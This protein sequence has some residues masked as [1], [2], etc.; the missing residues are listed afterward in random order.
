MSVDGDDLVVVGDATLTDRR[1]RLFFRSVLG[2]TATEHGWRCPR[3][4]VSL[5]THIIRVN[6]FLERQGLQVER[7]GIANREVEHELARRRSF[8]RTQQAASQWKAGQPVVDLV[9]VKRQLADYGW[10]DQRALRPHQEQGLGHA[11]TAAN[12][13]NFS[14]PGAGKTVTA[15][16][17]AATHLA[18]GTVDV[19]LVVGPLACFGPWE[20]ETA[21]ALGDRLPTKRVRGAAPARRRTYI[22]TRRGNLLLI[23]FASAAADRLALMELCRTQNVML[24]IDESHRIKR[25]KGGYWAPALVAVARH[26]RVRMVLS[27]T[28]MPQ[29]GRD[30][31]TQLNILW[32]GGELTGSQ[33]AFATQVD[34]NFSALLRDIQPFMARTPKEALG[35]PPYKVERH[36]V[37]LTGTQLEI[38][39][40]IMTGLRRRLDDADTWVDKLE[41]LRRARPIRLLQAACNPDLF[42]RADNYYRLPRLDSDLRKLGEDRS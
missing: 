15:L 35:L 12:A 13:A 34:S 1:T 14:V 4:H 18:A 19:V 29:N 41:A 25:F 37:P 22:G 8:E 30:L 39:D 28:P 11:L 9:E 21:A 31:Y 17:V 26:A 20:K 38:Y 16:A 40:L 3:R 32:P 24:V 23:S 10:S 7:I 2:A 33:D 5:S 42:N 36:Q 27:G 6:A